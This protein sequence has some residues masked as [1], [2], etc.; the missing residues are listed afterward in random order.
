MHLTD[1]EEM[2]VRRALNCWEYML[3]GREPGGSNAKR[4]GVVCPASLETIFNEI[5]GGGNAGRACWVVPGTLCDGIPQAT[6]AEKQKKCG[7]CDFYLIV[8]QEENEKFL[9]TIFLL[10]MIEGR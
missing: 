1:A 3:C 10:R 7:Q 6:F 4:D 5:H 2:T 8:K 9:P